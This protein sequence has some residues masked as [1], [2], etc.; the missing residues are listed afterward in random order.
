MSYVLKIYDTDLIKFHTL[1][2]LADPVLHITWI[3]E[4]K[5]QLL[6]MGMEVSDKGLASWI[7]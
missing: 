1:E 3:N 2:N 7:K 6:P 4:D 5:K